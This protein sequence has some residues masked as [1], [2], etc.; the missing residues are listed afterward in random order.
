MSF[1]LREHCTNCTLEKYYRSIVLHVHCMSLKV[2]AW[3]HCIAAAPNLIVA[4]PRKQDL[5]SVKLIDGST[6]GP[7]VDRE[8]IRHSND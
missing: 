1:V 6:D 4:L 5:S 7:H 8:I 2:L 3:Y